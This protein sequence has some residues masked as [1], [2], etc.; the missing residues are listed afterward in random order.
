MKTR[1]QLNIQ[2]RVVQL[3]RLSGISNALGMVAA[4][5]SYSCNRK[6]THGDFKGKHLCDTESILS[7]LD[8]QRRNH[9]VRN[10]RE[11][12]GPDPFPFPQKDKNSLFLGKL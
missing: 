8:L 4:R 1:L 9:Q 12:W 5:L 3:P 2:N 10:Y 11:S 6:K 7:D